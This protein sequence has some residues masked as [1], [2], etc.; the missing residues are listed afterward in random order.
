[1]PLH[2]LASLGLLIPNLYPRSRQRTSHLCHSPQSAS[3]LTTGV[4]LVNAEPNLKAIIS[5][6][7]LHQPT[8]ASSSQSLSDHGSLQMVIAAMKLKDA[9]SLEGK[10]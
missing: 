2:L 9:Y 10:S 7:L 4:I 8:D 3:S 1:M 5:L 6:V